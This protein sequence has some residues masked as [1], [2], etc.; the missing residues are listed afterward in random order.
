MPNDQKRDIN[1][2]NEQVIEDMIVAELGRGEIDWVVAQMPKKEAVDEAV[3]RA[4]VER[5][6]EELARKQ[7]RAGLRPCRTTLAP[8][9]CQ[10]EDGRCGAGAEQHKTCDRKNDDGSPV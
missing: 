4:D 1:A 6:W 8:H 9:S 5:L 10:H 3:L 7:Q 2:E